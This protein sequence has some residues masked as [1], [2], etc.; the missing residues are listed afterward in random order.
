MGICGDCELTPF[1]DVA[2]LVRLDD[3][4]CKL[5]D[6]QDRSHHYR[7]S[8]AIHWKIRRIQHGV[9]TAKARVISGTG[10]VGKVDVSTTGK[11]AVSNKPI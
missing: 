6:T 5:L 8:T 7:P 11:V 10:D 4:Y 2:G 9:K 3:I 1:S